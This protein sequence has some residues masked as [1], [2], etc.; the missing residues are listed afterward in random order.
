M[1]DADRPGVVTHDT[2]DVE[3]A[4]ADVRAGADRP[5]TPEEADAAEQAATELEA[6][7][8]L[9]EVAANEKQMNERGA[10]QQGEGRIA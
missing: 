9:D 4:Q 1:S 8:E 10:H 2:R 3:R 5:P 6:S 7:G